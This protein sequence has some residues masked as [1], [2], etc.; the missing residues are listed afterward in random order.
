[1]SEP[2]TENL[3]REVTRCREAEKRIPTSHLIHPPHPM[4]LTERSFFTPTPMDGFPHIHQAN[5]AQS[6]ENFPDS[7]I[8]RWIATPGFKIIVRIFEYDNTAYHTHFLP[9]AILAMALAAATSKLSPNSPAPTCIPPPVPQNEPPSPCMLVSVPSEIAQ[10]ALLH[11]RI[12][13]SEWITFEILPPTVHL[14][15]TALFAIGPFPRDDTHPPK[16]FIRAAWS[17]PQNEKRIAQH[18]ISEDEPETRAED[19][20]EHMLRTLDLHPFP[21]PGLQGFGFV[22]HVSTWW[23]EVEHWASVKRTLLMLEYPPTYNQSKVQIITLPY[24]SICHSVDHIR[25]TC[26]FPKIPLWNGPR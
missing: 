26:P 24:C 9:K 23:S 15:P 4:H 13:S 25:T 16:N 21:L 10:Q 22:V 20:T 12:W 1:M 7:T 3:L 5:P 19:V 2:P 18:L 14:R 8:Q 11:G 6:L 17:T